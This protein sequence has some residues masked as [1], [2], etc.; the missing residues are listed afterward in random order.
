MNDLELT[1]GLPVICYLFFAGVGAGALTTSASM[2]LR[3][4]QSERFFHIARYGSF[5][6]APLVILGVG[7]LVF[8]LGSFQTGNWFK[9]LNLFKVI[10]LSPMSIGT[11]LLVLFILISIPYT[12]TFF[13]K[14]ARPGD[15]LN[16]MRRLLAWIAVPLG[17][18]V[19]L[20]TG[21]LLGAMPGRPFWNSPILAVLFLLSAL[22]TGTA[23]LIL[24]DVVCGR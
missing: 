6:A 20:Y 10:N 1:W 3:G 17:I 18:C 4:G 7:L 11:W 13:A 21:V 14:N 19:A 23:V 12:Y 16:G 24:T 8:E 15:S 5:L 2:F 22:S 9:F